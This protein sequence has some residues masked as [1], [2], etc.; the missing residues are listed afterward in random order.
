MVQWELGWHVSGG[1]RGMQVESLAAG[2]VVVWVLPNIAGVGFGFSLP[3][4]LPSSLW[5]ILFLCFSVFAPSRHHSW[6]AWLVSPL[7]TSWE[8]V[9]PL[10]AWEWI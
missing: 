2:V 3:P 4:S 1:L 9:A 7:C 6:V 5:Q 8:G 10:S